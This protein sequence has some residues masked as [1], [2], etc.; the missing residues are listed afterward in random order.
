V[1]T[2]ENSATNPSATT[3]MKQKTERFMCRILPE[4]RADSAVKRNKRATQNIK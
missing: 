1:S 3:M 4:W 2:A